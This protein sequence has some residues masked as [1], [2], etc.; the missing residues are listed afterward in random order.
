MIITT[1]MYGIEKF[2]SAFSFHFICLSCR[3][4]MPGLLVLNVQL[5]KT[6]S[7]SV[8]CTML[9]FVGPK[10]TRTPWITNFSF[11][12][13]LQLL[14]PYPPEVAPSV[15]SPLLTEQALQLL[16]KVVTP[17]E[18]QLWNNLRDAW[19]IPRSEHYTYFIHQAHEEWWCAETILKMINTIILA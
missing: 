9:F 6:F 3:A 19:K 10:C 18:D 5:W 7:V 1:T 12:L 17:E 11:L 14:M 8:N 16:R 4:E 2:F 13:M 15:V